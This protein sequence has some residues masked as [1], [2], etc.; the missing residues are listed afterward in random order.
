MSLLN[1]FVIYIYFIFVHPLIFLPNLFSKNTQF[2]LVNI[3]SL[4]D[5]EFSV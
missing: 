5:V 3:L 2:S 1:H 4:F